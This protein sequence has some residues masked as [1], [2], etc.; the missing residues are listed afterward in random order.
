LSFRR[1]A[2]AALVAAAVVGGADARAQVPRVEAPSPTQPIEAQAYRLRADAFGQARIP[3]GLI[4]LDGDADATDWARIEA[5]VWGGASEFENEADLLVGRIF[6]HDPNHNA[7]LSAGRLIVGPG[8]VRPMHLDGASGLV[9]LPW[10]MTVEAFGG[11]GVAPRFEDRTDDWAVGGR[12]G[13]R[14]GRWGTVGVAYLERYDASFLADREIGGDLMLQPIEEITFT[15]RAAW[16]I[17]SSGFSEAIGSLAYRPT[18]AWRF[19]LYGS[20]RAPDRILPATS[21][22]SVL[23]GVASQIVSGRVWYR[24][25]PRLDVSAEGG[26]R[27]FEDTLGERVR[28]NAVLRLDERGNS[29]LSVEGTRFGGPDDIGWT[30]ARGTLRLFLSSKWLIGTEVELVRPDR[31]SARGQWWPWALGSVTWIPVR[32]LEVALAIEGSSTAENEAALD[33]LL[34]ITGRFGG[35]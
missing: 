19:E 23:G 27:Q 5:Q 7:E 20:H 32:Q 24:V 34:R 6:L 3:T 4:I 14:I 13:Q 10:S 29:A 26:A 17:V 11:L 9:R 21:L 2:A 12:I 31:P 35:P 30:G 18:A 22:F 28:V 33:G 8:A 16:D 15:S 25:A 1:A